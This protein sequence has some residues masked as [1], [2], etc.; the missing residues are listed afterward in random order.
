MFHV[1]PFLLP[2][3]LNFSRYLFLFHRENREVPEFCMY[4]HHF[5]ALYYTIS[6]YFIDSLHPYFCDDGIHLSSHINPISLLTLPLLSISCEIPCSISFSY[7]CIFNFFILSFCSCMFPYCSTN[8]FFF[9]SLVAQVVKNL[10]A[11]WGTWIWSL[12]SEDPLE[13]G[14][15]TN[16]S[17]L[18]WR[19][20]WAV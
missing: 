9:T 16:S 2:L 20:P 7:S 19:I 15:A 3:A 17:I 14:T 1:Y 18:V 4:F 5:C 12:G 6:L 10:P 11:K 8:I 13:K